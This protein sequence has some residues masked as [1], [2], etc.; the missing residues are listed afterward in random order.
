[1]Q[2]IVTGLAV[3]G[4]IF[5]VIATGMPTPAAAA[6]ETPAVSREF[7]A[8]TQRPRVRIYRRGVYLRPNAVR[9][10]R[11]WLVTEY[12]VSGTVVTPQMRC[13]WE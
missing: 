9:Q 6:S 8:Q 4:S 3:A 7:A 10:C 13:W 5:L 2:K 1:M 11:S 12:R